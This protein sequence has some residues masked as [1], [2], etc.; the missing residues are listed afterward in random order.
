MNLSD[1]SITQALVNVEAAEARLKRSVAASAREKSEQLKGAAYDEILTAC[2][3][4]VDTVRQGIDG[5]ERDGTD[6]GDKRM[7]ELRIC[8]LA[9][10]YNLITWR[11]GRN[12][13]LI[14]ELDG[15][16]FEPRFIKPQRNRRPKDGEGSTPRRPPIPER[17]GKKLARLRERV[18]LY[19]AIMQS[20]ES[21][22][23][24]KGAARDA[25]FLNEL[26]A[27][28]SYFRALK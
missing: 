18:A 12:R 25:T 19:D 4:A 16:D 1:A 28:R 27:K 26:D 13:T 10:S 22:K 2:Q 14:G 23:E 24:L 15:A 17:R 6:E 8:H 5:L 9:L 3:D 7:Q 11:V 21:V 20:I